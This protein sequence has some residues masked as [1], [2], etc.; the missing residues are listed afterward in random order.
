MKTTGGV[1]ATT[2]K[3]LALPYLLLFPDW[4]VVGW[5]VLGGKGRT[6]LKSV[7]SSSVRRT[8]WQA[9]LP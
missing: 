6:V 5:G 8:R 9:V 1:N 3:G 2:A 4:W 7:S